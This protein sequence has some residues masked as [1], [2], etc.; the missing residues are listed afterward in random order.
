MSR[1]VH[2]YLAGDTETNIPD[3]R[4]NGDTPMHRV[5]AL[6]TGSLQPHQHTLSACHSRWLLGRCRW[7]GSLQ[8]DR[9]TADGPGRC[10]WAGSLQRDRVTADGPGHCRWTGSL[11]MDRVTADGPGHCRWARSLRM[12]QV[13]AD[14]SGHSRWVGG[15]LTSKNDVI[16]AIFYRVVFFNCWGWD[17]NNVHVLVRQCT[18]VVL[19]P[20]IITN[21][22]YEK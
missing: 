10:R 4:L 3:S 19:V 21:I 7:A 12:G 14:G 13:T 6:A 22:N 2:S 5:A 15:P 20:K 16:A 17:I 1:S 11:Q 18:Y 8:M 9:V